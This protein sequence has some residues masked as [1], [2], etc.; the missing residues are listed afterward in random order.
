MRRSDETQ[1]IYHTPFLN[2]NINTTDKGT[3]ITKAI[4]DPIFKTK[5][6]VIV[7]RKENMLFNRET[8]KR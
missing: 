6:G 3:F 8:M 5:T 1:K 2:K 7:W 4:R